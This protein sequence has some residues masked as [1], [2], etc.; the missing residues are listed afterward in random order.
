MADEIRR[1]RE[2]VEDQLLN[3]NK[4]IASNNAIAQSLAGIEAELEYG[5]SAMAKGLQDLCSILDNRF[6]ILDHRL[7]ETIDKLNFQSETLAAIKEIV[8][9][10]LDTQA[11]E[12]RNRAVT[13]YLNNWIEEA[14]MDLLEAEKKNYQDFVVHHILGNI[15]FYHKANYPKA[16]E[17]YQ[18]SAKYATPYSKEYASAML[19][20]AAMVYYKLGRLA[21][22]YTSAKKALHLMPHEPHILYHYARYAAKKGYVSESL[23]KLRECVYQV[24]GYL[25][26]ADADDIFLGVKEKINDLA[27][28]LRDE[29]KRAVENLVKEVDSL[30]VEAKREGIKK[31]TFLK[32]KR[33]EIM[34]LSA[35]NSYFDF[36]KAEKIAHNVRRKIL[37]LIR[38]KLKREEKDLL[39]QKSDLGCSGYFIISILTVLITAGLTREYS[40]AELIVSLLFAPVVVFLGALPFILRMLLGPQWGYILFG[41]DWVKI[42]TAGLFSAKV[43]SVFFFGLIL[44]TLWIAL[45]SIRKR[46]RLKFVRNKLKK[47]EED[48]SEIFSQK[49]EL[50]DE[51][52]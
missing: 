15:Y 5:F 31:L 22:A 26:T 25:I 24:P 19:L 1:I 12:L 18:K 49:V 27:Q 7:Q 21:D 44:M 29:R 13:A 2:A 36:L 41:Q 45:V 17:Y 8:E 40:T 42:R 37:S 48:N 9:K 32:E 4:V 52:V 3:T 35:R 16:L 30:E 51:E 11:K 20:N 28:C 34:T 10:P 38:D 50:T 46:N 23:D 33:S 6:Q 47:I 39:E 43:G 14:E